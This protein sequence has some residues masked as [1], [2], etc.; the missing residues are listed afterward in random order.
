MP[1][2]FFPL[3]IHFRFNKYIF[4]LF[5]SYL[6]WMRWP[7]ICHTDS[8]QIFL[9]AQGSIPPPPPK[10]ALPLYLWGSSCT[11]AVACTE[12]YHLKTNKQTEPKHWC[13]VCSVLLCWSL[14]LW[15]RASIIQN[16]GVNINGSLKQAC[17]TW[18][19]SALMLLLRLNH[20]QINMQRRNTLFH[21]CTN[22]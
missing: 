4:P 8:L 7:L 9:L 18:M 19:I 5:L 13:F 20:D 12:I 16:T 22:H 21:F 15:F 10:K 3:K 6:N 14:S 17:S 1:L 11:L 2:S